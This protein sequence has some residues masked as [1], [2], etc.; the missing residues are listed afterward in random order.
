MNVEVFVDGEDLEK[1]DEKQVEQARGLLDG[2]NLKRRVHGPISE[3]VPGA[4]DPRIREVTVKR[5]LQ[6]IEF[7]ERIGS[8]TVLIHS[9][10]DTLNKRGFEEGYFANLVPVVKHLAEGVAGKGLRLL[11]E[12]TFEPTPDLLLKVIS[13]VGAKNLSLCFDV[14]HRNVFGEAPLEVWLER[15]AQHITAVHITDNNGSWD[16][17]FAPGK[18]GIDF[19]NFFKLLKKNGI[20]PTFTFEPHSV[21]AFVETIE[22]IKLNK[23][24]F[25]VGELS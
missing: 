18:G 5:V 24:Y 25:S 9:G 4:F 17:H 13:K 15:C 6:A 16:D 20:E 21:E 10:Y 12:N 14:A 8:Q 22:F 1:L 11:L 3:M 7:A 23:D 2:H 19:D